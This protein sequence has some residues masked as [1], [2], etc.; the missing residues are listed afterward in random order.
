MSKNEISTRC[1]LALKGNVVPCTSDEVQQMT[2]YI[3]NALGKSCECKDVLSEVIRKYTDTN[4]VRYI[5]LHTIMGMRCVTYLLASTAEDE[6]ERFP[7]PFEE[8]YGTG[9]PCA[10]CYVLN[11]DCYWN[12]EFSDCFFE[13]K[14]DGYYHRIS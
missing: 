7:E 5:V 13:K 1:E 8:D 2:E 14:D 9:K 10:F 3:L 6:E 12:S 11:V 4:E